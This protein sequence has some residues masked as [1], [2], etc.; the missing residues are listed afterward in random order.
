ML[1][2]K[3]KLKYLG[4]NVIFYEMAKLIKEE[5]IQIG[6]GTRIDDFCFI[7]GGEGVIFGRY[8]HVCSFASIT[9]GGLLITGDYVGMAAGC[10]IMTGTH[11]YSTGKHMVS[12][13][14]YDQQEI[15]RGKVVLENDVFIGSNAIVMPNVTIGEGAVITAGSLVNKDIAPWTIN[16]GVPARAIGTRPR[17]Q[18]NR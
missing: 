3:T 5:A 8:N 6:D 15:I 10:R 18:I 1:F 14:P 11:D 17:V 2:D 4:E 13:I 9:G 16:L 7:Y 12:N